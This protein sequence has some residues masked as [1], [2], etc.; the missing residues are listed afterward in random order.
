MTS[1]HNIDSDLVRGTGE[2]VRSVVNGEVIKDVEQ[3]GIQI[4][5]TS[6][7]A[8]TRKVAEP[9]AAG[10]KI[11]LVGYEV[12]AGA[13]TIETVGDN[14]VQSTNTQIILDTDG[15][16]CVLESFHLQAGF[17]WQVTAY[18]CTFAA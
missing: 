13:V 9:L 2:A 6:A 4:L 16:W 10:Q 7:G 11:V 15:E 3:F 14:P 8:E 5:I 1:V 18:N 12:T 17:R